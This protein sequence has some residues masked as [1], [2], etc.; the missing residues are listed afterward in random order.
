MNVHGKKEMDRKDERWRE[1]E[2]GGVVKLVKH[3]DIRIRKE[4]EFEP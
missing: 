4:C 3:Q 1:K 2:R